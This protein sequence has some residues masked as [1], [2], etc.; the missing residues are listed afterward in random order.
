GL[1]EQQ[2]F[3]RLAGDDDRA[4][5]AAL[6]DGP[7]G[8]QVEVAS[9]GL[10]AVATQALRLQEGQQGRLER[11]T[12]L[13][14]VLFPRRRGGGVRAK[15]QE[16]GADQEDRQGE[17]LPPRPSGRGPG[18]RRRGASGCPLVARIV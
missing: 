7:G 18:D 12:F 5:L 11:R 16:Q 2:T 9:A 8:P 14:G 17:A 1:G 10:V 15:A 13:G 6:E 3:V 4:G